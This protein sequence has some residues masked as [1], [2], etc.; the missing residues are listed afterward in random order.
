MDRRSPIRSPAKRARKRSP[1]RAA[2]PKRRTAQPKESTEPALVRKCSVDS[3]VVPVAELPA[4][5]DAVD[6]CIRRALAGKRR[7]AKL[8]CGEQG[9]AYTLEG[10]ASHVIKVSKFANARAASMWQAEAC[11]GKELGALGIAPRIHRMFQCRS[12]GYIVM[13][14][15]Q[16]A[17]RLQ[18]KARTVIR[19]TVHEKGEAR[20]VDH[21]S[22]MPAVTQEG[23][24]D[25]LA[26]MISAGY[27]HMDNHIENLG[28][29][30]GRPI[31]FDFGFTQRRTWG[32]GK[33]DRLFALAFSLFNMLEHCPLN[34][35]H[36]T[37]IWRVASGI[38]AD[39]D[40]LAWNVESLLSSAKGMTPAALRAK[41]PLAEM[42]MSAK[43]E[44]LAAFK[45]RAARMAELPANADVYVGS[46][47]YAMVLQKD[48]PARY[49]VEPFYSTLYKIRQGKAF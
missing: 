14:V 26:R 37:V 39:P 20:K 15:L 32:A 17:R 1:K 33:R 35:M 48:L 19:E 2:S 30:E 8:G 44:V 3:F 7:G 18:D 24:I 31:A 21:L 27:I 43:A 46:M 13:D 12:H 38:L 34:E 49:D 22:R 45:L 29:I 10:S 47:C 6:A 42:N 40:A 11:L 5:D 28:Y 41:F 25:V 16:D 9:C 4:D 36:K 23:F